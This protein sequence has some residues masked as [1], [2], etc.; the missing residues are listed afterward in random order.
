MKRILRHRPSPG[1]VLGL[2]ALVVAIGGAAFAAIP[3][4]SGVIHGCYGKSNGSLRVVGS[5]SDCR[6][7]ETAIEWNQ[8][9]PPG[10]TGPQGPPGPGGSRDESATAKLS[11]GEQ[12]DLLSLGPFSFRAE[13]RTSPF[14]DSGWV[15]LFAET[16]EEGSWTNGGFG[17]FGPGDSLAVRGENVRGNF[18][19]NTIVVTAPSGATVQGIVSYGSGILGYDCLAI[20]EAH[21]VAP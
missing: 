3:D 5:A 7:N 20:M 2:A 1:A 15:L 4:S 6:N 8:Q 14:S 19:S 11:I 10:A 12:Q 16:T 18:S 9:G 21:L 17:V 13:C